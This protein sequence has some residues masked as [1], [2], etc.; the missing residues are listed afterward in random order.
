MGLKVPSESC[1]VV[2]PSSSLLSSLLPSRQKHDCS[3]CK[4][5][6][7]AA[8]DD[9]TQDGSV[10]LHGRPVLA[11]KTGKWKAAA[12]LVGYEAFERMAYYGVASNLVVYLTTKLDEDTVSST[13]NVNYWSGLVWITPIFGAY[14]ADTYLG[15][16]WT[17]TIA[18]LVY[19]IG[20]ILL[21]MAVSLK[22]LKPSCVNQ[23]CSK[24]SSFQIAF[25]YVA[26]YIIAIGAGGT[27]PNI[28]TFGAD[29]FDEFNPHEKQLKA[30]FF[31]WWIFGC[32]TGSF[33][34]HSAL[35]YIQDN[36]SWGVGYGIAT[37]GLAM[38]L[39]FFY[40]GTPIY[41]HKQ[42]KANYSPAG[43]IVKVITT[44]IGNRKLQIPKQIP[45]L[46]ELEPQYYLSSGKEQIH[47]TANFRFLDKAAI[48]EGSSRAPCTVTQVQKTKLL[49]GMTVIWFTLLVPS[50]FWAEKETI[51]IK[52]GT[53]MD[54]N[55]GS[56]FRVP[57]ASLSSIRDLFVVVASPFYDLYFVP[58]MRQRTS[59]PRG[60]TILQRLGIGSAIQVV[61]IA[62]AYFVELRRLY[63]IKVDRITGAEDI[64]P[65]SIVWQLP[66]YVVMG[67]S[68]VFLSTGMLE[69]FY[70]QS[71]KD[72][73]SLGTTFF[74]SAVG[75]GS[76]LHSFL[77][78]LVDYVSRKV[79]DGKSWIGNNLN[80]SHLDCYFIFLLVLGT[81]NF[82][83]FFWASN[84]YIYKKE[85][86][87]DDGY[88]A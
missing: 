59:N 16:F 67:L 55:L 26:L 37:V 5:I 57:P 21:T 78:K 8:N 36:L 14:I 88:A 62:M 54:C 42:R 60:I 77:V 86:K 35:V 56:S 44:A 22:S 6:G 73:Q 81:L 46:H 71:P 70:D 23:F 79:N 17:F 4:L 24:A 28:S 87:E 1:S 29:Q 27:K 58:F 84:A 83:A 32:Y 68:D 30:A 18:S 74:T 76:F 15:R 10:D 80:D 40:I 82:G 47:H 31:N 11:S 3:S 63:I 43:E 39:I 9:L 65:M 25:F 75:V 48:I 64:V 41:R 38:S 2:T 7:E 12:L 52:Q 20:M 53:T 19:I 34:A 69:F 72:M 66:Q 50:A 13:I 49:I 85:M 33:I 45:Q 51:F 61:A